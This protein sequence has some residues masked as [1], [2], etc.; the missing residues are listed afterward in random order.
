MKTYFGRIGL[1]GLIGLLSATAALPAMAQTGSQ[2]YSKSADGS[3]TPVA[4]QTNVTGTPFLSGPLT[5]LLST[6][7]T[8]TNWGVAGF[9]IYMPKSDAHKAAYGMGALFLYNINPYVAA[10]V[11]IDWLDNQTTMPSGQLQLQAPLHIGGTN[12]ITVTPFAFTGVATP[13][14]GMGDNNGSVVGLFGAGLSVKLYGG[15]Q[16]FYAIEQRTGQPAVWNLIGL[17]F[18]KAF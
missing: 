9:G 11:G 16:G 6:M 14:S 13:V 2:L 17:A 10:G 4:L 18:S 12:G 8:A 15:L 3:Y 5:D 1:I 7:S